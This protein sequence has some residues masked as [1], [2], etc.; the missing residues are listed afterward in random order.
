MDFAPQ[1]AVV[2]ENTMERISFSW[3]IRMLVNRPQKVSRFT[4]TPEPAPPTATG[5]DGPPF[6]LNRAFPYWMSFITSLKNFA[7]IETWDLT[8]GKMMNNFSALNQNWIGKTR[9][10]TGCESNQRGWILIFS[11]STSQR[12]YYSKMFNNIVF[13]KYN[14]KKKYLP[15]Y[16]YNYLFI[17]Y[18]NNKYMNVAC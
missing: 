13:L 4:A 10:E 6:S 8:P 18:N 1:H 7:F 11:F 15:G 17:S 5:L 12:L 3:K 16:V 14:R 2:Y 9:Q